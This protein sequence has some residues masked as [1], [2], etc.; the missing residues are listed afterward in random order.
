MGD[1]VAFYDEREKGFVKKGVGRDLSMKSPPPPL[2][3]RLNYF[4][5]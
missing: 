3:Y 2:P 1:F 5:F 4:I